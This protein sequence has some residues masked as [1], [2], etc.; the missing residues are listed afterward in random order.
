MD[1][2]RQKGNNW[3]DYAR[4]A[5]YALQQ[6][7]FEINEVDF[8]CCDCVYAWIWFLNPRVLLV[9]WMGEM[10]STETDWVLQLL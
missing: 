2:N 10:D 4:G 3:G 8:S 7:G 5:L 1:P 6:N 9:L